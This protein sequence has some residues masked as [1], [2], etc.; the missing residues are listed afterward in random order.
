[1]ATI[2]INQFRARQYG[3]FSPF[4]NL[5]TLP[6]KL[7]TTATGAATNA[8]ST[9]AIASGDKVV[10]GELPA[11]MSLQDYIATV[12][13]AFTALVTANIGF[14]YADGVDDASVPQNASYF[15]AAV[16]LN[17]AG[18]YRKTTTT[19]PVIL[20]KAANLILTTAGAAN[21]KAARVDVFVLGELTGA[22]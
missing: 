19:A 14:E 22:K 13:T 8:N 20:P 16:A 18:V 9:A 12:S 11:G 1:M 10:L 15:G 17:T 4:G 5:S 21:A 7:E 2:K 3:G 6:F